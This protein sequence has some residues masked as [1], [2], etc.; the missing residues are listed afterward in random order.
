MPT[1]QF[2]IGFLLGLI[3]CP[4]LRLQLQVTVNFV[5]YSKSLFLLGENKNSLEGKKTSNRPTLL[6]S[7]GFESGPRNIH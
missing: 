6:T 3:G 4:R 5:F 1:G 7:L 2:G